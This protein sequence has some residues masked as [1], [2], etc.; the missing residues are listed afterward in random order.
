[1]RT[2]LIF[3]AC[4]QIIGNSSA[5]MFTALVDME[6]L[7]QTEGQVTASLDSYL[8]LEDER[9]AKL[10]HIRD[11]FVRMHRVASS[12]IHSYLANP[13][14][15][16]ILVKRLT[17]DWKTVEMLMTAGPS[18]TA[19][20]VITNLTDL[21]TH[22][23]FPSTEDLSGAVDALLRL[24]DTYK[25]DTST[26]AKGLITIGRKGDFGRTV[27]NQFELSAGDC[28]ELGRHSYSNNDFYH[29]VLWMQEALER[30]DDE[31]I[32]TA[33]R[34]EILE[35]LAFST[36]QR[37]N[38]RHALALTNELLEIHPNHPRASGNKA[39]YERLLYK[40]SSKKRGDEGDDVPIDEAIT[41]SMNVLE[42]KEE[43]E[44]D[45]YESLCRGEKRIS[46]ET[47]SK[48]VCYYL[49]TTKKPYLRLTHIKV[50][51]AFKKP[52]IVVYYDILSDYEIEVIKKLASPKLKR[53]TVQNYVTGDLE[54]ARYRISKSAWLKG[55]EHEVVAKVNQRIEEITD[56]ATSTAEELQVVNYGIGGHYEPHYD[57]ARREEKNA[58]KSLGTGNRIA[59]WL[60]YMSDVEAGGATVFPLL[61]I[62]VWPKKGSAVFWYNLHKSGEGDLLTRHA[63]CPVLVG[64]KWVSNKWFHERGQEFR[65]PCGLKI[66]S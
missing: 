32:K 54:I 63:A 43:S 49:D 34:E 2:A 27:N 50:E 8:R 44:R 26:L 30:L 24:Q 33:N 10:R 65:R 29:T 28:F 5:E 61:G 6:K 55:E 19:K 66:N 23:T 11:S 58:F 35:Y 62:S 4:F 38:I 64:S 22:E 17:T 25:L 31:Q 56:L 37:G 59:T 9:L 40:S 47:E 13:V 42:P 48:L 41:E 12:D 57:F 1:M 18:E 60:N 15:A 45:T 7:L 36:Y 52:H 39:Y 51:E 46:A 14:N 21:S 20:A 53:A 3:I 16:Y